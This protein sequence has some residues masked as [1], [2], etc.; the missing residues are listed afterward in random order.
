MI[1]STIVCLI[2]VCLMANLSGA[3]D[4]GKKKKKGKRA[5]GRDVAA[6]MLGRFKNVGLSDEQENKMKEIIKSFSGKLQELR[7]ESN[8]LFSPEMRKARQE[9]T[10]KA[11]EEGLKG[12]EA[13]DAI[14]K[15]APITDE[16][17]G[18][19]K[20][21]QQKMAAVQKELRDALTAVLTDEQKAK[22]PKRG[23]DGKKGKK[24]K[25]K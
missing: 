2:A 13:R 6:Q 1:R 20:E 19:M 3:Q 11:R 12:K 9:A 7:K 17:A 22:L 15:A 4:E 21:V 25:D 18:K 16:I 23:G 8:G 5:G 10:K 24:K 14:A